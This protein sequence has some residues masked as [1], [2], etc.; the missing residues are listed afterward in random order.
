[1]QI[2]HGKSVLYKIQHLPLTIK[3]LIAL[4]AGAIFPLAL[5]PYH[6]V[7]LA[8]LS[9]A[10]LYVLLWE[11]TPKH[12]F[13]IGEAYGTGLWFVG[14]FWLYTSI[15][16]YGETPILLALL[17]VAFVGVS[18]GLF[19]AVMAW[20]FRLFFRFLPIS[21][22]AL[23]VL[24]EWIKTWLFTGFPWLFLGYAFT[25]TFIDAYAPILG[26]F[27]MT[28]V[29]VFIATSLVEA[30]NKRFF[31]LLPSVLLVMTAWLTQSI[32]WTKPVNK[33]PLIVTL[34]QGNIPQDMKWL[35]EYR[36]RTLEI[37]H[38]L[39]Y[40]FWGDSDVV[41]WPES[42][43]PMFQTEAWPFISQIALLARNSHTTWVTGVPYEAQ[44][45]QAQ[46][47]PPFYNSIMALGEAGDGIYHKQRLVPFGE[48]IPL[49]GMLTW[50]LPDLKRNQ[51][52]VSFSAGQKNQQPLNVKGFHL[53]AAV[54]Y[55]VAYPDTTRQNA[56]NSHFMITVS[57]DA[58]FG[59]SAGPLQHLQ[60]V[61]LR[62]REVGRWFI[63]ATN[64]G[65]TAFIDEKGH[66]VSQATRFKRDTLTDHLPAYTGMTPFMRFGNIP[67]LAFCGFLLIGCL[68]K[69]KI[70]PKTHKS[71]S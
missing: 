54:C 5:A 44:K 24:Q 28:F 27:S 37:Y 71:S 59:T 14:A 10:L 9:P 49:S 41:V 8:L 22:T 31:W 21:F 47:D 36:V 2:T 13:W 32:Q 30:I 4:I 42:A 46:I 55:E 51:D 50:V 52:I 40:D 38:E 43:I 11:V 60:M 63:R 25:E 16:V 26:V 53:G 29:G 17:M 45:T 15:H 56:K 20:S 68:L 6:L 48:Y 64:T 66:V 65:V 12:A 19:H 35:T 70:L 58:W 23:W 61:Q 34:I 39:S 69:R 1:M 7:F 67:I 18:M 57:N 33:T 62:A 3:M